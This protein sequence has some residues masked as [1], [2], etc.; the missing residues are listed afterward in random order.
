M[1]IDIEEQMVKNKT[2]RYRI[3]KNA[4]IYYPT[5]AKIFKHTTTSISFDTL[6]KLCHQLNCT[7]N[8]L[9]KFGDP[10]QASGEPEDEDLPE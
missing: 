1:Y 6:E 5:L 4:G 9:L 7:P 10:P 2:T 8:D 3:S